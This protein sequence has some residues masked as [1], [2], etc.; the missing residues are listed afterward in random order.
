[1]TP[2]ATSTSLDDFVVARNPDPSSTLPYLVRVP[3]GPEGIVLKARDVWP[4]TA[5]VYCHPATGW[6][7]QPE[8]VD[9]ASVRS[10]ARRGAAIDLVLDRG[11]ENRSQFVFA[12][13]R[14][15]QVIFWQSRRTNRKARP[16]VV[17]PTRRASG[18][19]IDIVVDTR[20]RYPW[21]FATQQATTRRGALPV[22]DYA[23]EHEGVVV[24][25]VER[26]SLDDLATTASTGGL[27]TLLA[28]L[29][30]VERAALVVEDRYGAVFRHP[31]VRPGVLAELVAEAQ[32]RV[33]EVPIVF[34]DSRKLAEE[35]AFRYLGAALAYHLA[36]TLAGD[37]VEPLAGAGPLE[38]LPPTAAD[39]RRWAHAAG[40][41]VGD[42]GRVPTAVVDAYWEAHPEEG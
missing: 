12:Q 21:R 20:E 25:V 29:A 2:S 30:V 15:R 13:A 35:W 1:M 4:R 3:L 42:R 16:A 22:G 34:A 5:K 37:L 39:I 23:V 10:C 9:R 33:P 40:L 6:P 11:R 32:V 31:H 17:L 24:A 14:G 18:S 28:G 19:V 8:I 27:P 26:K 38:P 7:D 41:E 36:D